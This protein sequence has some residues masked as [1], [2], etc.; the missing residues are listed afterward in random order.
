MPSIRSGYRAVAEA[1]S[2]ARVVTIIAICIIAGIGL[3]LVKLAREVD[4]KETYG[5]DKR[6]LL[7]I[8]AH[9]TPVLDN[10]IVHTTDIGSPL[11]ALIIA[12]IIGLFLLYRRRMY[13]LL[14]VWGC[15]VG[16]AGFAFIIKVLI[17]RP[18]PQLWSEQLVHE[19]GFSFISGHATMS[20][21]LVLAL[22][23][24]LWK[25]KWRWWM[26][27]GGAAYA[28]FVSF[29]RL[30]LGVHYPTDILGGWLVAVAWTLVVVLVVQMIQDKK[31]LN[32]R[33]NH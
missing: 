21:T 7:D 19:T 26:I 17:E 6:I 32:L 30:Y 24:V 27:I 33:K 15:M 1:I 13:Q 14:I 12:G 23:A 20:M 3:V 28:L 4:E 25:T 2:R 16:A 18:R 8:H 10:I 9:A 11:C 29:S 31:L 22:I 5:V